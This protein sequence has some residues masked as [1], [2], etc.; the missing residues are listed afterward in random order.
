MKKKSLALT[1][2]AALTTLSL[3]LAGCGSSATGL[4]GAN[5]SN[6]SNTQAA[7]TKGGTL[8]VLTSGTSINLDPAS[9][10]N[11]ATT[12]GGMI[13]RRLNEWKVSKNGDAELVPDLA[14]NTG[15]PS[16]NGK[17]WTFTLK[18]GL[19]FSNG[20]PITSK[21]VKWG[22]ERSFA[23]TF[24]GGL[25]YHKQLLEGAQDYH[26]PFEGQELN[27]IE[28]PDDQT[29]VFHL[30]QPFGDFDWVASLISFSPVPYG[31]GKNKDYGTT[32]VTT[33]PYEVKS[34]VP[35]RE[36]VMVR[37]KYWDASTDSVRKAYPDS[38]VYKMSQD[39][40]VAAQQIMAGSG[41]GKTSMLGDLVPPAQLAQAQANP[42]QKALLATSGDGALEYLAINNERVKDKRVREAI[43]YAT[44]REAYRTAAGG[45]IAGGYASTLITPGIS[46]REQYDLYKPGK[47]GDVK[48]A[49]A[50]LAQAGNPK[51]NL[52]LVAT[53]SQTEKA[54]AIQTALKR[55]GIT[56]TI[57]TLDSTVYSDT[58]RNAG[59]FDLAIS[60]WQP[61]FPSPYANI[62]PL[63]D[64]SQI[65]NGNMNES[66]YN[67]PEVDKLIAQATGTVDK[68]KAL[69]LWAE[70]DKRIMEDVPVVPLIY[71]HNTFLR[72]SKV[73]NFMIGTF[74]AYPDYLVV[75]LSK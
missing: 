19:K 4:G 8:T 35:G 32:P 70:V 62:A 11:L 27:S 67:N 12:T 15:K 71:S 66:H 64:S 37:N 53:S 21:D 31:E 6:G 28:T 63:F 43:L 75:G 3:A 74:P 69:K 13:H 46:G 65:G 61:D 22:L 10:Q 9:S 72:G 41:D 54:S 42:A 40:S 26:G 56:V 16:E 60:S 30:N 47:T 58:V 14:T 2:V 33:G 23:D 39:S 29:I 18:K 52:T 1:A 7:P 49:K 38:I 51:L 44:D 24:S 73:A 45:E 20:Q 48:K 34:N 55:A 59:D 36:L 50:L 25:S 57:K 17:V 5:A 68:A